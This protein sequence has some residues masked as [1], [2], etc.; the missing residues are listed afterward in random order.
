MASSLLLDNQHVT[1]QAFEDEPILVVTRKPTRVALTELDQVWGVAE[2]V[3]F[4]VDR[5]RSCLVIDV[6]KTVGR[7]E[8]DFEKA[9]APY[10]QRLSSDWLAMALVVAT[11]PG[12]L[13]VQRYAREDDARVTVFDDV[14]AALAWVRGQLP[15]A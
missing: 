6:T 15:P 7:N 3:L 4:K 10:R 9:F 1:V 13:Q 8:E 12:K 2:R 11:L 14:A 5:A